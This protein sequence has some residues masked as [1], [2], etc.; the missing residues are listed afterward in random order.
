MD[1]TTQSKIKEASLQFNYTRLEPCQDGDSSFLGY[2]EL[3]YLS[4]DILL[5][6]S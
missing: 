1:K 5:V 6:S 4:Q 3:M 2:R